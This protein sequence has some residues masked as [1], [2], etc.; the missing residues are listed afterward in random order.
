MKF[1]SRKD[2]FFQFIVLGTSVA[3]ITL[4]PL[5]MIL[6]GAILHTS[7]WFDIP[8]LIGA[9]FLLW[10]YF[11][12]EYEITPTALY[13]KSGPIKGS[14]EIEQI[15][16]ILKGKTLWSGLKPAMAKNGLIIKYGKY[17]EIYI[18][19][20]TNDAFIEYLLK[21]NEDIKVISE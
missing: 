18:S 5:K 10:I 1:K 20:E 2:L 16:E 17:N 7:L 6:T 4:I 21:F 3:I 15:N 13:Y 11:S 8:L 19:P 9:G 14:I 12:T